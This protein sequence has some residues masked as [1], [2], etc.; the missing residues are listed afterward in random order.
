MIS[1]IIP[2]FNRKRQLITLLESI[3]RNDGDFEVIIVDDDSTEEL[4]SLK[5]Q[6]PIKYMKQEKSSPA[7]ARNRGVSMAKGNIIAFTDSDCIVDINWLNVISKAFKE[8]ADLIGGTTIEGS[9][10]KNQLKEGELHCSTNNMA[11][12]KSIF[13]SVGG[14]DSYFTFAGEDADFCLRVREKG[15]KLT[16]QE[17]MIIT[18]CPPD[19]FRG[20]LSRSY[21]YEQGIVRIMEKYPNFRRVC[22]YYPLVIP[23]LAL[24]DVFEGKHN[25]KFVNS[26][27]WRI[28]G[29]FGKLDYIFKNKKFKYLWYT[30]KYKK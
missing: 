22:P 24:K 12:L 23:L 9:E 27:M 29:Y 30:F 19:G 3:Y 25:K 14:F 6:F 8:N 1:V 4:E 7:M 28:V 11:V 26:F 5:E 20:Y 10:E 2:A 21:N 17:D 18:H 13:E 16:A 15:Y